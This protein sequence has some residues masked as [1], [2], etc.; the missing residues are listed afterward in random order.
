MNTKASVGAVRRVFVLLLPLV[1]L[2][3]S[4]GCSRSYDAYFEN[5]C[6]QPLTVHTYWVIRGTQEKGDEVIAR[7]VLRPLAVTKVERAFQNANGFT[8]WVQV[9][10]ETAFKVSDKT[11]PG[12]K[13]RI[14][15]S[16]CREQA[17][18]GPR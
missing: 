11:M 18:T 12:W 4:T 7:A 1:V 3:S 6:D 8:W 2:V 10:G 14:P 17:Q 5:P 15:I 9:L 13:V 16:S